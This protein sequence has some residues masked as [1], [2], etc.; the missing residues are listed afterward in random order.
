MEAGA[1]GRTFAH[2]E[3]LDDVDIALVLLD[4][5]QARDP[6]QSGGD[7]VSREEGRE[8]AQCQPVRWQS[9]ARRHRVVVPGNVDVG[10][11][12]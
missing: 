5:V 8:E 2:V 6:L 12:A 3:R 4:D 1:F 11:M 7:V 9:C 10:R